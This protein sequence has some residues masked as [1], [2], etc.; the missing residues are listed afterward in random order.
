MLKCGVLKIAYTFLK[1]EIDTFGVFNPQI[2]VPLSPT[3]SA[4]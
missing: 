3:N 1:V 4:L 2:H